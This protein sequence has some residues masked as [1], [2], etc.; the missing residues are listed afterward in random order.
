METGPSLGAAEIEMLRDD[1]KKQTLFE[2]RMPG[3]IIGGRGTEFTAGMEMAFAIIANDSDENA[4]GQKGWV[5]W[6]NHTIVHGKN[7]EEMQTLVLSPQ[8]MPVH[9]RGKLPTTWGT[10]KR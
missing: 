10:L 6:G 7:P 3:D 8:P 1:D 9:A 5:G 2:W 4:K